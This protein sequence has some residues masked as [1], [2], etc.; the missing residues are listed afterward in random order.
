M[1]CL[2]VVAIVLLFEDLP[3]VSDRMAAAGCG[4]DLL[5]ALLDYVRTKIH[6]LSPNTYS[7]TKPVGMSNGGR[8][9]SVAEL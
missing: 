9:R 6:E 8:F 4:E 1:R 3:N 2:V 5:G 7:N